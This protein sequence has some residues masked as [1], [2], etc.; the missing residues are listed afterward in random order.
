MDASKPFSRKLSH[1]LN[2]L[3][4][5]SDSSDFII[6]RKVKKKRNLIYPKIEL[7]YLFFLLAP[8]AIP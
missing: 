2:F 8:K 6:E 4:K 7:K 1:D 5:F 3:F